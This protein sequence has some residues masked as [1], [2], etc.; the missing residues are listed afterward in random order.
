MKRATPFCLAL[1]GLLLASLMVKSQ[2]PKPVAQAPS[3][4]RDIR[5]F[6][7]KY[8]LEC[9]NAQKASSGLNVENYRTLLE[10]GNGGPAVEPGKPEESLL[11]LLVE[12]KQQPH[13]P[14]RNARL[15][16]KPEEI[17]RLRAWIAA[18]AKDDSG[19]APLA[20]PE[21]KS[22]IH[23]PA[24][25]TAIAYDAK[26]R[27]LAA[28]VGSEVR[29]W[30]L[31]DL[32][33]LVRIPTPQ[34]K[35]TALAFSPSGSYL[36]LAASTPGQMGEIRLHFV[37]PSGVLA[38][39][40]ETVIAAHPDQV[41]GLAF[42]PDGQLLASCSYDR[43]VKLWRMPGGEAVAALKDHSDSVYG[44]ALASHG[45]LLA[46]VGAD[47]AVKIWD[48]AS[49]KRL[50][51]FGEATDWLYAVA[52]LPD[53]R[54]VAA[55]GVDRS[56]RIWE[57]LPEGGRLLHS[58]FAHEGAV[59]RLVYSADGKYLFSL[60]E[61][62]VVKVWDAARMTEARVFAAQ[63][64]ATFAL[65][66]R[67]DAQQIAVGR[68]DGALVLLDES[69]KVQAQPLPSK[70]PVPKIARLEPNAIIR[71]QSATITV[72]GEDLDAVTA[73]ALNIP[74]T[75]VELQPTNNPQQRQIRLE[76]PLAVTA[77]AYQLTLQA[78]GG[79]ATA[80]LFVDCFA[81]VSESEP[82]NS[83]RTAPLVTLPR[84][85][86]GVLD[87]A[88]EVDYYRF[89]AKAGQEIGVQIVGEPGATLE[90]V[91][92]LTDENGR[93][94]QESFDGLLAFRCPHTATYALAVHDRQYRGDAKARYRL[95]VGSV[96]IV[97]A[98]YP[99]GVPR[100]SK[101][102]IHLFG[103]H[104]GNKPVVDITVPPDQPVGSRLPI[105]L[106]TPFGPA[107]GNRSVVVAEFPESVA[108]LAKLQRSE[109]GELEL[110]EVP[111]PGVANG[112]LF[113]NT[114][115]HVW[116]FSAKRSQPL[117]IEVEARRLGS[118]LDSVIEILDANRQPLPRAVLRSVART[119]T[120]FR[121][122]D[123]VTAGI[124][125]EDWRELAIND[126]LYVNGELIRILA[127]PRNPDDDCRFFNVGGQ[128]LGYLDTTPT[129]HPPGT[130]MYKVVIHP[131]GS[132]FPPNGFPIFTLYYRNDDGGPGYGKDSRVFFHP[133]ADGT[134]YIRLADALGLTAALAGSTTQQ[135]A[136]EE[137]V[138]MPYRLIVRPPRPDF[139]VRFSPTQP[140]IER[141]GAI[142]ITLTVD[143][144][145]G[146]A[147]R[148][149]LELVDLP[150]G[151]SAPR[152][153]VGPEE[154]STAV[155]LYAA[156][157]AK[158]PDKPLPLHVIARA[159]VGEQEVVREA[160]GGIPVL[161]E[162]GDIR[163]TT[164]EPSITVRP[165]SETKLTVRIERRN[166]FQ[167]RVPIDV[168]GLPHGV[169]VLDIGLNG[170]LVTPS[171]TQ[172]TISIYCEPWVSPTEHPFVVF[173][174][175]EGKNTVHAAPSVLLRIVPANA[176]PGASK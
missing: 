6:L 146:F 175:R 19:A 33:P 41:L 58:V 86:V 84:T 54:R 111:V 107:L 3:F 120:T 68:L 53:G 100:N 149:E 163:T 96:P 39:K 60:G 67:P 160:I 14:P 7:S 159:R 13:M 1:A 2:P 11:L 8:C 30:A 12:K 114:Q 124:R 81:T 66:V 65:A 21:I 69:G 79:K 117:I 108:P 119:Y 37:P 57:A 61:D 135:R 174:R 44:I 144:L 40:P 158:L 76:T 85:I 137:G 72:Y 116:R 51:T 166:N 62:R 22:K 52:W 17:A 64:E 27:W 147:G 78:P 47:R 106:T 87:R 172:R 152:T 150:A 97:T 49:G 142:P 29:M 151:L 126:Y 18:G 83:A 75:Q 71:G 122:H 56:I 26:G 154:F 121:D 173:A 168:T 35:I 63:P 156:P 48:V 169:R 55:A 110:G 36:A 138:P 77:G 148:V 167:G 140:Q 118:P 113:R 92:L 93:V 162:P 94:L 98:V 105:H 157:D 161:I 164:V 165:G 90:P 136:G 128:R 15:Q 95:Q 9:H 130:P 88:G 16:P 23:R 80:T 38:L 4:S 115:A 5:P 59:L 31:P 131:P 50:Y 10:G 134:Y 82:N 74:A 42:S 133:P 141:G 46:S 104:L 109:T 34:V 91:L 176:T 20:L 145:D 102:Q 103:V 89:Q 143:R 127:L 32:K 129:Y 170:I 112:C 70:P 99:L 43:L 101:T 45:K 155:A 139:R 171:E 132:T 24:A 153:H 25:V 28:G 123:N 125:I 73:A